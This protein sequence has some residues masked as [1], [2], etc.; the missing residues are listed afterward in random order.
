[1]Q[2][3]HCFFCEEPDTDMN[4]NG[5][6]RNNT[7]DANV[8]IRQLYQVTYTLKHG[9][10]VFKNI[11]HSL[12]PYPN[13]D[14]SLQRQTEL[15]DNNAN[16]SQL[17]LVLAHI[18]VTPTEV[19]AWA[20]NQA[21]KPRQS[22]TMVVLVRKSLPNPTPLQKKYLELVQL[23]QTETERMKAQIREEFLLASNEKESKAL[24]HNKYHTIWN[25]YRN[26]LF[27]SKVTMDSLFRPPLHYD[28]TEKLLLSLHY[29]D[30]L[31]V[32]IATE[33]RPYMP[34]NARVP[35]TILMEARKQNGPASN[36]ILETLSKLFQDSH[37]N[38]FSEPVERL[39]D[40]THR[41]KISFSEL[42]Y[43]Q[44]F[45]TSLDKAIKSS[46]PNAEILYRIMIE[47]NLNTRAFM[48]HY[49]GI[50]QK[51]I[52]KVDTSEAVIRLLLE[53]QKDLRQ[54]LSL[55]ASY[56][57]D[58]PSVKSY[59]LEWLDAELHYWERV[60][61]S[62]TFPHRYTAKNESSKISVG[63]SVGKL[64]LLFS[65]LMEVKV[66]VAE[67]KTQLFRFIADNFRTEH[68]DNISYK[69]VSTKCYEP[70]NTSID[71]VSELLEVMR[72]QLKKR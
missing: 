58:L 8:S 45:I 29:I 1:M 65:L 57:P 15:F 27:K 51:R 21:A 12:Y 11:T 67:S 35:L 43:C 16:T 14:I 55:E 5:Y 25:L 61:P 63:V 42:R 24:I 3:P 22:F 40:E 13:H 37:Y 46:A 2:I 31:L 70:D 53:F 60:S 28:T 23:V 49:I 71:G 17:G 36:R 4:R 38:I 72:E 33:Y 66:L 68:A 62:E 41:P 69:S 59:L 50:L 6:S 9:S 52:A 18:N 26:L 48:N 19:I 56:D 54:V 34:Q 32:F 39:H 10:P 7:P 47:L 20:L 30:H 64:A 44:T